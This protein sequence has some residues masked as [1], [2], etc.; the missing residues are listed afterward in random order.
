MDWSA[1]VEGDYGGVVDGAGLRGLVGEVGASSVAVRGFSERGGVGPD[2]RDPHLPHDSQ[3]VEAGGGLGDVKKAMRG[4]LGVVA[5]V[6]DD[7]DVEGMETSHKV[8][9]LGR[10]CSDACRFRGGSGCCHVPWRGS[11]PG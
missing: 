3:G 10:L 11:L 4:V 8:G 1:A 5:V 6:C 7:L 2:V 9:L